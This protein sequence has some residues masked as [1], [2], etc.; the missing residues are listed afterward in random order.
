MSLRIQFEVLV[1][2]E[3]VLLTRQIAKL[4]AVEDFTFYY[5]VQTRLEGFVHILNQQAIFCGQLFIRSI[6]GDISNNRSR[7]V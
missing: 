5:I 7:Q 1:C 2:S 3:I 6:D 4:E